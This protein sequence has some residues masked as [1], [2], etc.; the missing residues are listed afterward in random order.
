MFHI[1]G[2]MIAMALLFMIFLQDNM[3]HHKQEERKL[4]RI[5]GDIVK[6]QRLLRRVMHDYDKG[7]LK[8]RFSLR[9]IS[10]GSDR[11]GTK[12]NPCTG[13]RY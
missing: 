11:I 5:E 13:F 12:L 8:G 2:F 6:K 4:K 9:K 10:V 7:E 1:E 3:L